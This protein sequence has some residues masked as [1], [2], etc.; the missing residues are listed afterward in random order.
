MNR[1]RDEAYV[2]SRFFD[3]VEITESCWLWRAAKVN[4][5]YGQFRS[6]YFPTAHAHRVAYLMM[7]GPVPDGHEIDHICRVHNC[8]N[9]DH[10]EAVTH[11]ENMLRGE[12]VA[13]ANARKTHCIRG[14]D[15][16]IRTD[17]SRFC[18]VCARE[19][20]VENRE[21]YTAARKERERQKRENP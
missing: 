17:G 3:K 6:V 15:L 4:R 18:R 10:L 20:W 11:R 21:R 13:A 1:R 2:V 16:S 7:V 5:D 8:V 19:R 12:T 9:P 14:H